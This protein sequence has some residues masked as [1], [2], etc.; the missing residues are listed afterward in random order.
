MAPSRLLP[1]AALVAAVAASAETSPYYLGVAQSVTRDSNLLRVS[2]G[3]ATPA[4]RSRSDTV[5]NSS[6]VAGIDQPISRQRLH[7]S[8]TVS[9]T[10]YAEND[11]FDGTTYA[12]D[13]GLDWETAG[14]LSGELT[15]SAARTLRQDV[16]TS[17][18][19]TLS[20]ANYE[21]SRQIDF[22]ARLGGVT[23]L[24]FELGAGAKNID[25]SADLMAFRE[26]RQRHLLTGL[27]WR[28]GGSTT[29]GLGLRR[30][31]TEYPNLFTGLLADPNDR[32]DRDAVDLSATWAG[33]GAS[34]LDARL[35]RSRTRHDVLD[36]RDFSGT[37]GALS[38]RWN[39]GGRTRFDLRLARDEGQDSEVQTSV[40][41][42]TTDSLRVL[43]DHELSGKIA[44]NARALVFRR[45][46]QGSPLDAAVSGGRDS[47][48]QFGLGLRWQAMR[49]LTLGCDASRERRG[50]NSDP[51]LSSAYHSA[52]YGCNAQFI[53]Q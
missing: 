7:G 27:R 11:D 14:R 39:P 5:S 2:D 53:L 40:Y 19:A 21:N 44:L 48:S 38:W 29:F 20:E 36:A 35:S 6:L 9:A 45:R 3:I 28:P 17:A 8:A 41:S 10:R 47:G 32:R 1:L 22:I 50:E 23:P 15:T 33:G 31:H 24:T 13:L 49:S 37:S 52:V 26:Y 46:L 51:R 34:T 16:R 12:L 4:G 18:G 30:T 42:R 25:Y 43:V